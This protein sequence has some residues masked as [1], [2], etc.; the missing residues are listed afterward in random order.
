M[1][2]RCLPRRAKARAKASARLPR[3]RVD[4]GGGVCSAETATLTGSTGRRA[5]RAPKRLPA[6][7]F[8]AGMRPKIGGVSAFTGVPA[9]SMLAAAKPQSVCVDFDGGYHWVVG[10]RHASPALPT[11]NDRSDKLWIAE[12]AMKWGKGSFTLRVRCSGKV[13]LSTSMAKVFQSPSC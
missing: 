2:W 7:G 12:R 11:R 10:A 4:E 9:S 13:P 6:C 3:C 8:S 5:T 1:A